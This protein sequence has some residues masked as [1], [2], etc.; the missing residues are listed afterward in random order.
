MNTYRVKLQY[1]EVY[2]MEVE[3]ESPSQAKALAEMTCEQGDFAPPKD[4]CYDA[5]WEVLTADEV[6]TLDD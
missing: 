2:F 6:T 3:A 4:D 1:Y 5:D